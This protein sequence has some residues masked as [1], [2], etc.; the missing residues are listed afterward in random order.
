M[1]HLSKNEWKKDGIQPFFVPLHSERPHT[2]IGD[3]NR[4]AQVCGHITLNI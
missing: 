1:L 4:V 3:P 2:L